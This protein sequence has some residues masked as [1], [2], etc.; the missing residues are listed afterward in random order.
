MR[1]GPLQGKQRW[2]VACQKTDKEKRNECTPFI[3]IRWA[4]KIKKI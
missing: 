3:K 4:L 2:A 1:F